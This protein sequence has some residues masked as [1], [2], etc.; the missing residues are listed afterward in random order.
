AGY[1][2]GY[3]NGSGGGTNRS[4]Q[5]GYSSPGA[6]DMSNS[7]GTTN[8]SSS[9]YMAQSTGGGGGNGGGGSGYQNASLGKDGHDRD[10]AATADA[11]GASGGAYMSSDVYDSYGGQGG[12]GSYSQYGTAS[13]TAG[14]TP[15]GT[16]YGAGQKSSSSGYDMTPGKGGGT[17]YAASGDYPSSSQYQT[18]RDTNTTS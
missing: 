15:Q 17:A 8:N 5:Q 4:G 13:S 12:S 7:Y 11:Q 18:P 3:T 14:R 9:G 16:L 10:G 1:D 2:Q 6:N